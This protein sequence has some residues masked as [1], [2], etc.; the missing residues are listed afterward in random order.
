MAYKIR[1][2]KTAEKELAKLDKPSAVRIVKFLCE[3]LSVAD[4]P[5]SLGKQ[6]SG[7]LGQFWRFRVGDYR[8][9]CDIQDN[10]LVILALRIAHR[11]EVY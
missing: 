2:T 4:N 6:L 10:E 11:K 5:K 7:S 1:L 8:I 3:R 9:I